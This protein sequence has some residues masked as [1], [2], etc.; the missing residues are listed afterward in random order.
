MRGPMPALLTADEFS[1]ALTALPGWSEQSGQ[2]VLERRFSAYHDGVQFAV[3]V[4]EVAEAMNH[5][6]EILIRWRRVRV[7]ICTHSAG[8][9]TA[10]DVEFARRVDGLV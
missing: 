2:L 1:A 9:L 10:L 4:A 3:G 5:H 7:S 6:P 8:G